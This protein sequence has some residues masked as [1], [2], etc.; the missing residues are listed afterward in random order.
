[1][2]AHLAK[3]HPIC[4][5]CL[6]AFAADEIQLGCYVKGWRKWRQS[7]CKKYLYKLERL[8]KWLFTWSHSYHRHWSMS[9]DHFWLPVFRE[10]SNSSSRRRSGRH[11][12]CLSE[13]SHLSE[14]AYYCFTVSISF[15][16]SPDWS[17]TCG[18][19]DFPI[20]FKRM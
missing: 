7:V 15:F 20:A 5:I 11:S 9:T 16:V 3:H 2:C 8:Q 10:L 6:F 13:K 4:F 1:M 14:I 17:C 19:N 18:T 12:L